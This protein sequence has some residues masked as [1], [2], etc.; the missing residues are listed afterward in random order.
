MADDRTT[1]PEQVKLSS[2]SNTQSH[3]DHSSRKAIK[4]YL[5][6]LEWMSWWKG[7]SVLL[8]DSC[9]EP[10]ALHDFI[11]SPGSSY[12]KPRLVLLMVE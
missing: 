12:I 5:T 9:F 2:S 8:L 10:G 11:F 1:V 3:P 7:P 4:G 6:L